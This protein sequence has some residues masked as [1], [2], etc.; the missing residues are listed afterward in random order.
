MIVKSSKIYPL[1]YDK[2]RINTM[3]WGLKGE[4]KQ[5]YLRSNCLAL[6][7]KFYV[8]IHMYVFSFLKC[9]NIMK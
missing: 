7:Y 6:M 3:K 1:G 2:A 4:L 5:D 8:W 9:I